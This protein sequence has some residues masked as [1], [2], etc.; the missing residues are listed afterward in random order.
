VKGCPWVAFLHLEEDAHAA[1]AAYEKQMRARAGQVATI[2][3][4]STTALHAP[5][6]ISYL[7]NI[8]A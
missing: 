4:E 8:V 6:A 5:G 1:I 3:M 2:T 7:M